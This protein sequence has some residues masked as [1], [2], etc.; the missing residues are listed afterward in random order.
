MGLLSRVRIL[1][2]SRL[3]FQTSDVLIYSKRLETP[4][5][6]S[7][8]KLK[9]DVKKITSSVLLPIQQILVFILFANVTGSSDAGNF[10]FAAK[11][12]LHV[13]SPFLTIV[14]TLLHLNRMGG[15]II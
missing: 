6:E 11:L 4:V 1:S 9:G 8:P 15:L 2:H 10:G 5:S 13:L 7:E 14:W 12:F 3:C